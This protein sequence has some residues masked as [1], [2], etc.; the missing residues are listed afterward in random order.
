MP[1]LELDGCEE[2]CIEIHKEVKGGEQRQFTA[3]NLRLLFVKFVELG[4]LCFLVWI[5]RKFDLNASF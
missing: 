2:C 5:S 1:K 4:L 3:E